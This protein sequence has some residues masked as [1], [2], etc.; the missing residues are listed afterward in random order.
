MCE[1]WT[2]DSAYQY[3]I[4][5]QSEDSLF[6]V[7]KDCDGIQ[8]V[9]CG[10]DVKNSF[11]AQEFEQYSRSSFY[12]SLIAVQPHKHGSGMGSLIFRD[13]CEIIKDQGFENIVVR[14]RKSNLAMCNLLRSAGF[15][16]IKEYVSELGGV[17]CERF[18]FQ[19]FISS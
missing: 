10:S 7:V 12:V 4:D 3:F 11:I 16:V 13:Y 8:A 18:I 1:N 9:C 17:A 19:K 2:V 5:R 15:K 14:C 6:G